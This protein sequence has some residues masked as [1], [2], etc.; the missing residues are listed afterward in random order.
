M[1]CISDLIFAFSF[2]LTASTD[3]CLTIERHRN[4]VIIRNSVAC[5]WFRVRSVTWPVTNE[6]P[7]A[8]SEHMISA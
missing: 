5:L 6:D 1:T 4:V 3:S 7:A 2:G 8:E